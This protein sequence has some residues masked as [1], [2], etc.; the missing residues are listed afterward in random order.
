MIGMWLR[1]QADE[2]RLRGIAPRVKACRGNVAA[3][4]AVVVLSLATPVS[5]YAQSPDETYKQALML[6]RN[7]DM[8]GAMSVLREPA[9]QGHIDSMLLLG[10]IYDWSEMNEEAVAVYQRAAESGSP[11]GALRLGA[12]YAKGE[13]TEQDFS[14]AFHWFETSAA[15]GHGPAYL[16]IADAYLRGKWGK[17]RDLE[18]ADKWIK[19]AIENGAPPSR[20]FLEAIEAEK[21]PAQSGRA[22]ASAR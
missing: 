12:L 21:Q 18:Q 22:G 20:S 8:V 3:I 5:L 16:V 6:F 19:G 10:F 14:K 17:Q 1:K 11:E 2:R 15:A 13:G 4:I 9:E 7:S